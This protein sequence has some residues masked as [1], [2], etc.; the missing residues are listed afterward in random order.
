[1]HRPSDA[2]PPC[3]E[4]SANARRRRHHRHPARQRQRALTPAQRLRR[5]VHRHQ[6]RR[7]RGVHRHRRALQPEH[8]RRPGPRPRSAHCR[9][10]EPSNSAAVE[11]V[12]VIRYITPVNTP[13]GLPRSDAGSIPA[14]SSASH[15]I[16]SSSRCCGSIASAS[17]GLI[18]KNPASNS[19]ASSRNPPCP[20]ADPPSAGPAAACQVPAPVGGEAADRVRAR[21]HQLPQLLRGCAPRPG[22]GT[23]SPRSPPGHRHP[24]PRRTGVDVP[25]RAR[26]PDSS[27]SRNPAR[28]PALG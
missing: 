19:A 28:A 9:C 15:A 21:A 6:R 14:R 27:C 7:A 5:Q 3:R 13:V 12:P 16:S 11:Q 25:R 26:R 22:S 17:R 20:V 24:P 18:P 10:P 8:I 4:N 23:P 1:M 2:S